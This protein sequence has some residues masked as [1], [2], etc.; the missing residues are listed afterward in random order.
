M[1]TDVRS[2]DYRGWTITLRPTDEYCA[3]FAMTLTDPDGGEK[4][5]AAAGDTEARA[6][7]R[8]REVVDMEMDHFQ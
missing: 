2:E 3:R 8:G 5:F 7:E 1:K 4:H 6:L